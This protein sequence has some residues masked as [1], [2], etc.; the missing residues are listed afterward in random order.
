MITSPR[1]SALGLARRGL[2]AATVAVLLAGCAGQPPAAGPESAPPSTSGPKTPVPSGAAPTVLTDEPGKFRVVATG[3][4]VPWD[5]A[6][7]P[8]GD[9]LVT[10]R[11]RAEVVLIA[12][13]EV[14]TV[15]ARID[16]A[17]PEGEGGLM[18]IALS[19]DFVDDQFV[20]LYFTADQDNRVVRYKY[21]NGSLTSAE[22][23]LSGIPRASNH[24]GGRIRFGPDQMLYVTTGDNHAKPAYNA[25]NTQTLD[26][27]IL[28]V[29]PSGK[30]PED[31]PFENEV[32]SYGHRNVQGIGWDAK[33]RMYASEFGS[34]EFDELNLIK[35]GGNY[36]WP[37]AEGR[38]DNPDF[39]EPLLTWSTDDASPSGIAVMPNGTVFLASLRGERLWR[40]RWD[41]DR[42]TDDV[43]F[44]GV[45]RLRA[46]EVV[47]DE[48]WLLTNNTSG[49]DPAK[50][51]DRL[52]AIG[53]S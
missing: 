27:K 16:D 29:T 21:A 45:G 9:A 23:I 22:P 51:D 33:G 41:G 6:M 52:I 17:R 44:D 24:N 43:Y 7:L 12:P 37:E 8:G 26:G 31:N 36:G 4:G 3:L 46:V 32:W 50:D 28:R 14:P 49:G 13:G 40:A 19:P 18:G 11:D 48:L 1:L 20:Y 34:G 47:G 5:L 2:V 42:M 25:Q 30:A 53:A 10:L 38:S 39:I 35:K 15:V